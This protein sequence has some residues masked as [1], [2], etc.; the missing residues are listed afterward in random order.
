MMR[1]DRTEVLERPT[2]LALGMFD[3]GHIGHREVVRRAVDIGKQ[4]NFVPA[5]YSFREHPSRLLFPDRPKALLTSIDEKA[6]M[7]E[8][9][10]VELA[11]LVDF[12]PELARTSPEDFIREILM[13]QLRARYISIGDNFTF[14]D[15][16]AGTAETLRAFAGSYPGA[17]ALGVVEPVMY[18]GERVS[19]SRLR[20]LIAEGRVEAARLLLGRPYGLHG[21]VVPGQGIGQKL[22]GIPTANL[23]VDP[24][25]LLPA[26]GVYAV[27][28][29][30]G[31]AVHTGALNI[32]LRPTVGGQERSAEVHIIGFSG[33]LLGRELRLEVESRLRAEKKFPNLGALRQQIEADISQ[34]QAISQ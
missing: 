12:T 24:K 26:D 17:F 2:A 29:H 7:L 3:G 25:K 16:G 21:Q 4:L 31:S 6:R 10:D 22:L 13:R 32:G 14:G 23:R 18:A 9:W 15:K 30:A 33:D 20:V 19:S 34:V 28:V 8:S 1:F 5:V 11:L 27:R